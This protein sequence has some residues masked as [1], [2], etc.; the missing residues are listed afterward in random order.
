MGKC[1]IGQPYTL[2][3]LFIDEMGQTFIPD[4]A[5][6][7]VFYFDSSGTKQVIVP[8]GT[9]LDPVPGVTARFKFTF[10]VPDTLTPSDQLHGIMCGELLGRGVKV[11]QE[12]ILDP[13][14]GEECDSQVV[15]VDRGLKVSFTR[16][17]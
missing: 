9:L 17:K 16:P 11:L 2:T 6:L 14:Y 3:I 1:V 8:E 15:V 12:E 7:E 10:L 5:T 13:F 4:T